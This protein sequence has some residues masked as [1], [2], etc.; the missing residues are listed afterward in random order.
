MELD[1]LGFY[2]VSYSCGIGAGSHCKDRYLATPGGRG[3]AN[4]LG[5]RHKL[6]VLAVKCS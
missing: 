4:V 5:S 2:L 1:S 6:H 3:N